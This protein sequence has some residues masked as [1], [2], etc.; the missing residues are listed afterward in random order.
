MLS[1]VVVPV[2]LTGLGDTVMPAGALTE[3]VTGSAKP[4]IRV[5]VRVAVVLAPADTDTA[6]GDTVKAIAWAI[7]VNVAMTTLP[8]SF[9]VNVQF[10]VA[11]AQSPDQFVNELPAAGTA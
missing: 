2:T 9:G 6:G 11:P 5:I 4:L 8:K 1:V 10:G 7:D 3:T